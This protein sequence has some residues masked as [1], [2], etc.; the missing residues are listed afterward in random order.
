MKIVRGPES[1]DQLDYVPDLEHPGVDVAD[2]GLA[3]TAHHPVPVVVQPKHHVVVTANNGQNLEHSVLMKYA[4][5]QHST[6][7]YSAVQCSAAH[8]IAVQ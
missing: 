1:G 8:C 5:V 3:D 6:V 4:A 7:Q 2:Q